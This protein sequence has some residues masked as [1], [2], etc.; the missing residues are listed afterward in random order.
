MVTKMSFA[1]FKALAAKELGLGIRVDGV[2]FDSVTVEP[3]DASF[4]SC[5]RDEWDNMCP[6]HGLTPKGS[7]P[8][9]IR[10]DIRLSVKGARK[11]AMSEAVRVAWTAKAQQL[12][13]ATGDEVRYLA[14]DDTVLVSAKPAVAS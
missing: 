11:A 6:R 3:V 2:G 9:M 12:A 7:Q 13:D 5:S 14:P 4:C 8:V 10:R 1:E